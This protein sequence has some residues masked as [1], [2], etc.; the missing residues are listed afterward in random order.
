MPIE[1]GLESLNHRIDMKIGANT[2]KNVTGDL[3]E[4]DWNQ[5]AGQY[6]HLKDI[7]FR[8]LEGG[9]PLIF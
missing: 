9:K 8:S 5:Y 2:I 4:V 3:E 7:S 1:V 6:K